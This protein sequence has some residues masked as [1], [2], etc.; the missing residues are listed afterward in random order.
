MRI[1]EGQINNTVLDG[2]FKRVDALMKSQVAV[3]TGKRINKPSD[4]PIG[5]A[6]ASAQKSYLSRIDQYGKNIDTGSSNLKMADSVL[7]DAQ[8][9]LQRA[10]ELAVEQAT[11]TA[12]AVTRNI[13]SQ[14]V[15]GL[16]KDLLGIA[17]TRVNNRYIFAG[18][19]NDVPPFDAGGNY[20]SDTGVIMTEIEPN[21][22]VQ[23]N[24]PGDAIFSAAGGTDVLKVISD[25][26][27]ALAGN[28]VPGIKASI[29]ELDASSSQIAVGQASAGSKENLLDT[30][31]QRMDDM[32]LNLQALLSNTEDV[33][34][35]DA[36]S[37][38]S[39]QQAALSAA[40]EV[41]AK[42]M[43]NSLLDFIR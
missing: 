15:G 20:T 5:A 39:I 40:R 18:F 17:N 12:S 32:K 6:T 16:F 1:T 13:A 31:R 10:K 33:D 30:S 37:Q 22:F 43:Q 8:S 11:G 14:E 21:T 35:A 26:S 25:L 3:T 28:D 23:T 27:T 42:L 41:G 34:I 29:D 7:M 2:L 9:I 24:L 36:I 38:L 4:D 19:K